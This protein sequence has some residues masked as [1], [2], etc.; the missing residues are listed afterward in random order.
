MSTIDEQIK[1]LQ[2][3]LNAL[4]WK[5]HRLKRQKAKDDAEYEKVHAK[6]LGFSDV[7]DYH[8]YLRGVELGHYDWA[9]NVNLENHGNVSHICRTEPE[10]SK[11]IPSFL[12][13]CYLALFYSQWNET[14]LDKSGLFTNG[15]GD[16][17][18]FLKKGFGPLT[19][20]E[21]KVIKAGGGQQFVDGLT[22]G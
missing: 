15:H 3:E 6:E 4:S 21:M 2:Q 13:N 1:Q 18:A 9:G 12:R 8:S 22:F 20:K 11:A 7:G 19:S 14:P 16:Y 5:L 10:W 17:M